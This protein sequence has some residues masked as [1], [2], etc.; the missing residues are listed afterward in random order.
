MRL[1]ETVRAAEWLEQF[2]KEDKASA[3]AL[4][5]LV[6]FVPGADV[7]AGVRRMVEEFLSKELDQV[8]AA[9][10][11]ILSIED[12]DG[13]PDDG[14]V[15]DPVVFGEFDPA[16]RIANSPGSEALMAHLVSEIR[17]GSLASFLV[18]TPLSLS[19]M[20]NAR[21]R[22]LLCITDYIGSGGQ[23][24]NYVETWY[25]HKT[26]KS[27]R[28]F[29]WLRIVVVAY[30][31]TP[32]GKKAVE[33]SPHIDELRIV[34]IAPGI[35]RLRQNPEEKLEQLCRIYASRGHLGSPLGY[36]DSAGLYASS[37][38]IPNN[39][40]AILTKGSAQWKPFFDNRS[41]SAEAA[42]EIGYQR[43][44]AD[45]PGQLL[46]VGQIK[47]AMSISAGEIDHRWHRYLAALALLPRDEAALALDLDMDL[48]YLRAVVET[49]RHLGLVDTS[50]RLT[51]E[52]RRTL[53][54]HRRRPRISS[55]GLLDDPSPYYPRY[56]K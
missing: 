8:P 38:S 12:M 30:A 3:Q 54:V 55:G 31:S 43:P 27:W 17:K 7:V 32:A 37:F 24:L 2:E 47:L 19:S 42:A 34:E 41:I 9:V 16:Q 25:R 18:P 20:E 26:I 44:P 53:Q 49:L 50:N 22:T 56:Q 51:V 1:S 11:P 4:L 28:S 29:G 33:A 39:L 15:P 36:R 6:R 46:N 35:E 48:A 23:V 40:P 14:T 52:G 10:V 45:L 13:I 5:N 21:S